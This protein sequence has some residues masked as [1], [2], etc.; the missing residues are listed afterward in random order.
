[1]QQRTE[2]GG[3]VQECQTHIC[4][5]TACTSQFQQGQASIVAFSQCT[6]LLQNFVHGLLPSL[7]TVLHQL[8]SL[9]ANTK[10]P[11]LAWCFLGFR[12][13]RNLQVATAGSNERVVLL[14][15]LSGQFR[16]LS[17]AAS[18]DHV[19]DHLSN[20]HHDL[21]V[22]DAIVHGRPCNTPL[23]DEGLGP[24]LM[25]GP[26]SPTFEPLC[27]LCPLL[28]QFPTG[29]SENKALVSHRLLVCQPSRRFLKASYLCQPVKLEVVTVAVVIRLHNQ[30]LWGL[31]L[32]NVT[33]VNVVSIDVHVKRLQ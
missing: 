15:Q 2:F 8:A 24:L 28:A 27:H 19:L 23:I 22:V 26:V 30:C 10:T 17:T 12:V 7:E 16:C 14:K 29:V 31:R 6:I 25:S 3:E 33:L 20:R 5:L 9:S 13:S 21:Y 32:V 1:M 11:L 4:H 18:L